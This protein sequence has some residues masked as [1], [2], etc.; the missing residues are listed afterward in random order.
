RPG[1]VYALEE[2]DLDL[3]AGTARIARALA[4]DGDRIEDTP[5]GNRARTIDLSAQTV[6][7]LRKH[8]V[9]RKR[10]QLRHGWPEPPR[11]L[12]CSKAG[13]YMDPSSVRRA[14]RKVLRAAQLPPF[15]PHGL[16]HTYASL[17]LTTA[18][19]P[20]L[21]YLQRMLGHA[22]IQETV[23][24]YGKAGERTRKGELDCLDAAP[25]KQTGATG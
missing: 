25:T 14:M 22:S 17:Y 15:S 23:D 18:A 16:R 5:K 10:D 11:P 20:N 2:G 19:H 3:D 7:I 9:D 4:D 21:D 24:T 8:L 1:E 6:A 13:A 12:F